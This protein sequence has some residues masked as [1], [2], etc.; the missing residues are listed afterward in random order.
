MIARNTRVRHNQENARARL[1]TMVLAAPFA[2]FAFAVAA[3][4]Q[5]DRDCWQCAS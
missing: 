2:L 1:G 5:G 4:A 3:A